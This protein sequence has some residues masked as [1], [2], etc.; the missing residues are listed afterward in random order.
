M[1][2]MPGNAFAQQKEMQRLQKLQEDESNPDEDSGTAASNAAQESPSIVG[3]TLVV[4]NATTGEDLIPTPNTTMEMILGPETEYEKGGREAREK[5]AADMRA[6]LDRS[7]GKKKEK[8]A[9]TD[10][11]T[12]THAHPSVVPDPLFGGKFGKFAKRFHGKGWKK[13]QE[14]YE[15]NNAK[16][17]NEDLETTRK[18]HIQS[19]F[20]KSQG[21]FVSAGPQNYQPA[22]V[23]KQQ[24]PTPINIS[25]YGPDAFNIPSPAIPHHHAAWPLP[26]TLQPGQLSVSTTQTLPPTAGQ[27]PPQNQTMSNQFLTPTRFGDYALSGQAK[28]VKHPSMMSMAGTIIEQPESPKPVLTAEGKL[29]VVFPNHASTIVKPL[30]SSS[31]AY[32]SNTSGKESVPFV[33]GSSPPEAFNITKAQ[34]PLAVTS[35]SVPSS[36]VP[37][38][39]GVDWRYATGK[40]VYVTVDAAKEE[41]KKHQEATLKATEERILDRVEAVRSELLGHVEDVLAAQAELNEKLCRLLARVPERGVGGGVGR[42]AGPGPVMRGQLTAMPPHVPHGVSAVRGLPRQ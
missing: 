12:S 31:S 5:M 41:L 1:I 37:V 3:H 6:K 23:D 27:C 10:T 8:Q 9:A 16:S 32:S 34:Q 11:R 20:D 2:P 24:I 36:P 26:T 13:N 21:I 14:W 29:S 39:A 40:Q 18:A 15:E 35:Y 38:P 17:E 28:F 33:L 30:A 22:P 25:Q 7:K 19:E 4:P 42:G